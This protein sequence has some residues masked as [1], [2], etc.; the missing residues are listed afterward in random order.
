ML[1]PKDQGL[2][3]TLKNRAAKGLPEFERG[4]FIEA[5][6]PKLVDMILKQEEQII[7]LAEQNATLIEELM[8][9]QED[10]PQEDVVGVEPDTPDLPDG[11]HEVNPNEKWT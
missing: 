4:P 6:V 3:D 2:L 7:K 10:Y 8:D 1:S 5:V 11:F 9:K